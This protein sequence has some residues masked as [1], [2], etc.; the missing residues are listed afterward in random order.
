M[1]EGPHLRGPVRAEG[2]GRVLGKDPCLCGPDSLLP[3]H[4]VGLYTL[5]T[6]KGDSC[7]ELPVRRWLSNR[8]ERLRVHGTSVDTD[9]PG[10]DVKRIKG[11]RQRVSSP[12]WQ[13]RRWDVARH[14][15]DPGDSGLV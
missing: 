15:G 13:R 10:T 1:G 2:T 3:G 4:P 8:N 6:S 9:V 5:V 11:N 7:L 12:D 14:F